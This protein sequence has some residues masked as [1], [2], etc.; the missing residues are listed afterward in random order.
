M[1]NNYIK[2]LLGFKDVLIKNIQDSE[3]SITITLE[4]KLSSQIC[5]CCGK[6][7]TKVHDYRWQIVKDAPILFKNT[8]LKF[9][10]RRYKCKSCGKQFYEQIPFVS[11]Y[12]RT[13]SRLTTYILSKL[14]KVNSMK[15][16]AED[17]NVSNTTVSKRFDLINYSLK[18][19]P[20]V[21]S[22]DEFR[23]NAGGEKYQCFLV[24][25]ENHKALDILP[26]RSLDTLCEYFKNVKN[27]D[28][29]RIF[30]MDM[31]QPYYDIAKTYFK[32]ALIVIDKYHYVR[33]NIWAFEAIRKREQNRLGKHTTKLFKGCRKLL[34]SNPNKLSD[35]EKM[36]LNAI[37]SYS[38]ELRQGYYLK[39]LFYEFSNSK[40]YKEAKPLLS[41]FI[42]LAQN[43]HIP[44]YIKLAKTLINWSEEILNSFRVPYTN[45]V[46][47]GM[48]NK[49]KVIKRNAYGVR[50]FNR[51]RNRILH[52]FN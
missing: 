42:L 37:L 36:Q 41:K 44:E 49:I 40:T 27:R 47:E 8:Y 46:I 13:T 12:Y 1:H 23:G 9:H 43:S 2:E 31:W 28:N 34:L 15:S 48:N 52:C 38:E 7:T 4:T 6:S 25:A 26:S 33:Q 22:I 29:V 20:S 18:K 5:P 39:Q 24:D 45:G 50:N 14:K 51:F 19:L 17:S 32:N 11:K 16:V 35:V 30:V 3:F 21:L 10:K